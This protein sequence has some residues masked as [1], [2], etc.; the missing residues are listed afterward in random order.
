MN[1]Q[2][3]INSLKQIDK[4][5]LTITKKGIKFSAIFCLIA[6][7]ILATYITIG[8]PLAYYIGISLLKSGMFFIT[9]FLVCGFAFNKIMGE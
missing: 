8:E 4:K 1:F 5:I 3:I 2:E 6:V 9:G 7:Y